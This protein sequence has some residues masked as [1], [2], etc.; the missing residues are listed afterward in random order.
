MAKTT[1]ERPPI[2]EV[3]FGVMFT[4]LVGL[5][6]AHFGAFWSL[7]RD[8]FDR[9]EDKPVV[10]QEP[11]EQAQTLG[12]ATSEW[13][14][15]PRVWFVQ[16][17]TGAILQLQHNRFH[18]NWRRQP[19]DAPYPRFAALAPKFMSYLAILS[20]FVQAEKLGE[21]DV[22]WTELAYINHIY[23][24]DGFSGLAEMS[25]VFP[26]LHWGTRNPKLPA[27]NGVAWKAV[28]DVG[29]LR[30][31][32][33][34]RTAKKAV[35]DTKVLF[36]LDLRASSRHNGADA[37]EMTEWFRIANE[38]VVSTFGDLTSE[39]MQ[40]EVWKRVRG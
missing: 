2:V 16:K 24:G 20:K 36:Q 5:K 12:A 27:P 14:P 17:D 10:I 32:S 39:T 37:S 23:E 15:L 26:D 29:D 28:F 18:Y 22:R 13:F 4:P 11:Q 9:T 30:I 38:A 7:I 40:N 21:L 35:D 19:A 33:E 25:K 31:S 1:Y 3:S 8:E 34:V 6:T